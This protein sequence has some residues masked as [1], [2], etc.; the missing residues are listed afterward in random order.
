[1][2]ILTRFKSFAARAVR[3]LR[4]TRAYGLVARRMTGPRL[5][6]NTR[7][8]PIVVGL[9]LVLEL[10]SSYR[11]WRVLL[12]GLGGAWLL[13]YVWMR[14]LARGL[15][16]SREVRFGWAQVGDRMVERFGLTNDS[17]VP[18]L[19]VEIVDHSTLPGYQASR[20]SSVDGKHSI[21]WYEEAVCTRRGLFVLGPTSVQTSDPFGL[22]TTT[23]HYPASFPLLVLPPVVPLPT[24]EVAPG[25]RAGE[26]RP[27]AYAPERTV[28]AAAVRDYLPGDS[29]RWI[30]WPTSARRDSLYVRLFDGTP[31]GDWWIFLDMDRTVQAGEGQDSTEEHGV[32]LAASLA[33]RGLRSGRAVG[34]VAHGG[35]LMWLPPRGGEGQRWEVMRSLALV[36]PGSCPLSNLL[37]RTGGVLEQHA[38]LVIITPAVDDV[39]IEALAPLL[40]RGITPTVLLLDPVSF[41]GTGEVGRPAALLSNL[42]VAHYVITRDLLDRPETRPGREGQW[43]WRV[44]G[45]GRAVP[46]R[47][48]RDVPWRALS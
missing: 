2:P 17:R 1:M 43:E 30:H 41:G 47:R 44:L 33:D 31:A 25:G 45:T 36:S 37:E 40:W 11:G 8:L 7:L 18:T 19:W 13:S 4:K 9:L 22:Y 23:V 39:W 38:S 14:V 12:V 27:R 10:T 16:L 42:G 21:R 15:R 5:R 35:G 48:P 32:I 28:A 3:A 29:P 6:L 20:V 26:G 46:V 24:I 34:L